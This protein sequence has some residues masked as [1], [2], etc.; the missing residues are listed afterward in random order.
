MLLSVDNCVS[1]VR[2]EHSF[3]VKSE[4]FWNLLQIK[5]STWSKILY[6]YLSYIYI[7]GVNLLVFKNAYS[8]NTY[9]TWFMQNPKLSPKELTDCS[10]TCSLQQQEQFTL[11]ALRAVEFSSVL[12]LSR[13]WLCPQFF[14]ILLAFPFFFSCCCRTGAEAR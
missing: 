5:Y 13:F 3:F 7:S 1:F 10:T 4:M 11:C 14:A 12:F 9:F 8:S 6:I 2:R